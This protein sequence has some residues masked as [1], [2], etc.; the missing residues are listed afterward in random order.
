MTALSGE[1]Y[2]GL[3]RTSA[4]KLLAWGSGGYGDL[5]NGSTTSSDVPAAV[6]MPAGVIVTSATPS[7]DV[8]GR[9]VVSPVPL[10]SR[11]SPNRGPAGTSVTITGLN[12]NGANKV[13]FGT[14][15]AMFTVVSPTKITATAPAGSGTVAVTVTTSLGTSARTA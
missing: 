5:G 4:G 2:A 12:L 11:L 14:A 15:S 10:V 3:A 6:R 7:I 1:Y 13:R 8:A 9:A